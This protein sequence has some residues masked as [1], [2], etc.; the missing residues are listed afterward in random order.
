[1]NVT[2]EAMSKQCLLIDDDEIM[3]W[4]LQHVMEEEGFEVTM[5]ADG[6]QGLALAESTKPDIVLL[7][8]GL[9]TMSGM[10]VL[11]ELRRRHPALPIVIVTSYTAAEFEQ[12]AESHGASGF[13]E[14]TSDIDGL[15]ALVRKLSTR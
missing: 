7:D 5:T 11:R 13:F 2:N 10:E 8:L 6:P 12:E 4:A 15:R 1:M 3:S 9:P 14:K